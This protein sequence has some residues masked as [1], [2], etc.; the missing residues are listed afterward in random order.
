MMTSRSCSRAFARFS[1]STPSRIGKPE[2]G[3]EDVDVLLVDHVERLLAIV[4]L[5]HF[6]FGAFQ[7]LH[8]R[9]PV[10]GVVFDDKYCWCFS[11]SHKGN[12]IENVDPLP[13]WLSTTRC[14]LC[15][16]MICC[17][18]A[19]RDLFHALSS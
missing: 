16:K 17:E 2:V 11:Y 15:S 12:R 10:F 9:G 1:S 13:A 6:V 19:A 5:Q 8:H 14:P 4:G 7:N 18:V 3:D